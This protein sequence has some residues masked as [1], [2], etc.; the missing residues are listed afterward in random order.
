MLFKKTVFGAACVLRLRQRVLERAL[1]LLLGADGVVHD[2][3]AQHDMPEIHIVLHAGDAQLRIDFLPVPRDAIQLGQNLIVLERP[4][5]KCRV[6]KAQQRLR[7]LRRR[8]AADIAI[9][10]PPER[11]GAIR[12]V[13]VELKG[14]IHQ[15]ERQRGVLQKIDIVDGGILLAQ[16]LQHA[17][18]PAGRLF[19][20]EQL[21][22]KAQLF[23]LARAS[24]R[25][26][27]SSFSR[28]SRS[29]CWL[30]TRRMASSAAKSM[31]VMTTAS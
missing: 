12:I 9:K 30:R 8:G 6:G 16:D 3:K 4:V 15:P 22:L 7:L 5:Q 10:N 29:D 18:L 1:L 20:L 14:G 31:T 17:G 24:C 28:V 23:S 11:A 26:S 13:A 21:F 25:S 27:S 2:G 19:L